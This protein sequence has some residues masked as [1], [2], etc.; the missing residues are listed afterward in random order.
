[1]KRIECLVLRSLLCIYDIYAHVLMSY[2][3]WQD[4]SYDHQCLSEREQNATCIRLHLSTLSSKNHIIQPIS[5]KLIVGRLFS[6]KEKDTTF[7]PHFSVSDQTRYQVKSSLYLKIWQE[8]FSLDSVKTTL[9]VV[10]AD[11]HTIQGWYLNI[12]SQLVQHYWVLLYLLSSP[13][14]DPR[15][16]PNS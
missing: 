12:L 1:M 9:E 4:T 16:S 14:V 3:A 13:A 11:E 5:N 6:T 8:R 2:W 15:A 10:Y 7:S